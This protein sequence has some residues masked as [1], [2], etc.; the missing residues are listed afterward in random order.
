MKKGEKIDQMIDFKNS[1][2]YEGSL[3]IQVNKKQKFKESLENFE[4]FRHEY[5]IPIY[6][7]RTNFVTIKG[8]L[9]R[10]ISFPIEKQNIF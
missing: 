7:V 6:V 1:Y 10:I 3:V 4:K 2:I 5:G 9:I 8:Q